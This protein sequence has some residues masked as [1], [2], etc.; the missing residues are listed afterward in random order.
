[1]IITMI[2]TNTNAKTALVSSAELRWGS[3][4]CEYAIATSEPFVSKAAVRVFC[5]EVGWPPS[6]RVVGIV[7]DTDPVFFGFASWGR[8]SRGEVVA[9][10]VTLW[11]VLADALIPRQGAVHDVTVG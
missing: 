11:L 1:M 6:A 7:V 9:C 5:R 4:C 8:M 3:S 2:N 10:V